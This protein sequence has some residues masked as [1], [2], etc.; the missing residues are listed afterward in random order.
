MPDIPAHAKSPPASSTPASPMD[1]LIE[2]GFANRDLNRSLLQK[3]DN[4]VH[5]VVQELINTTDDTWA[6][7]RH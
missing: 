1:Q 7:S 2:M 4:N 6:D 3:Y 5:Q